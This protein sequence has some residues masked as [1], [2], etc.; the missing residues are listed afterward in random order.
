[1][2]QPNHTDRTVLYTVIETM[3]N[4]PEGTLPDEV[5][6]WV[7]KTARQ[8]LH[9]IIAEETAQKIQALTELFHKQ[10]VEEAKRNTKTGNMK[11]RISPRRPFR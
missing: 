10:G 9:E 2:T 7:L 3:E 1:M 6:E 5:A 4:L 8:N 11:H